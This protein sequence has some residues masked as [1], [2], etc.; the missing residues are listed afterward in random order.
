[1]FQFELCNN[2][3]YPYIVKLLAHDTEEDNQACE[4]C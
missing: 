1:M 2:R 4:I 3:K